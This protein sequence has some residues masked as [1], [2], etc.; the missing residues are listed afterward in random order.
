MT[1][2]LLLIVATMIVGLPAVAQ[3]VIV[4]A[5][6]HDGFTRVVLQLP[7]NVNWKIDHSER[8]LVLNVVSPSIKFDVSRTF[9]RISRNRLTALSQKNPGSNLVFSL[10]CACSISSFME[11]PGLL[12][13]DI[14]DN[15]DN[16]EVQLRTVI[17]P[18]NQNAYR[19]SSR[20]I[21][22]I[23]TTSRP[24]EFMLPEMTALKPNSE[25]L[26]DPIPPIVNPHVAINISEERLLAQIGRAS[27]QGLL[28]LRAA[29]DASE[30]IAPAPESLR[31]SYEL[32]MSKNSDLTLPSILSAVTS[33]DRDLALASQ[34]LVRSTAIQNCLEMELLALH[35]WG[36]SQSFSTE[37][38]HLRSQIFGELGKV[39]PHIAMGLAR[40]YLF[41]GFG[42]EALQAIELSEKHNNRSQVLK[43]L[44]NILDNGILEGQNP[45]SGQQRCDGDVALWA[46]LSEDSVADNVNNN[47]VQIA[48]SRLPPH[49]RNH[50]GP[51]LSRKY[52]IAGDSKMASFFL[53]TLARSGLETG[54][55]I[56]IA[57][58][59][60]AELHGDPEAANQELRV[61]LTSRS[62]YSPEA[63]VKLVANK[64]E[65]REP[66]S[67]GLPDLAAAYALEFRNAEIGSD[68]RHTQVVA[69]ALVG[70]FVEAFSVLSN[71][72]KLDGPSNRK[73]TLK[74]LLALLSEHSDDVTFLRFALILAF[75]NQEEIPSEIG[76]QMARRLLDLGFYDQAALWAAGS[77]EN[78]TSLERRLLQAEI[79]LARQLPNRALV[80]LLGLTGLEPARL[81]AAALWQ[82]GEYQK[83]GQMLIA[84]EDFDGA[85]RGFW[86][87]E[88]W[89]A[90]P[91]RADAHYAQVVAGSVQLRAV[92][93][94]TT[95]ITPLAE[96]RV[97]MQN[98]SEARGKIAALLKSVT[99]APGSS[100]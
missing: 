65:A 37:I 73:L 8:S 33:I 81:R 27:D 55:G 45:F 84:A 51:R 97:L 42:A 23:M 36:G 71:M 31:E 49:L 30:I 39:K 34:S 82:I 53:R 29:P 57:K 77:G 75:E 60:L 66:V 54:S 68:L 70:Q 19:F 32:P 59:A 28:D 13:V 80:E 35:D 72:E 100:Q 1:R 3:T 76:D 83:A 91:Q 79:A 20:V 17:L 85:A 46:V 95:P 98:S 7:D 41:F 12:V 58:A 86:M 2:M 38:G 21:P 90:V 94:D 14:I 5:G 48:F 16:P 6:E 62:E 40:T 67:P 92:N 43:A 44:A 26:V 52:A 25:F 74:P 24:N 64:F 47:A 15:I 4:R 18:L 61:S 89:D 56:E 93:A 22:K 10:G 9:D 63:L 87:A 96:A 11:P 50:L 78:P 69:L 99:V 88:N